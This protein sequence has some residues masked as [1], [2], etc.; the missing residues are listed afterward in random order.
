MDFPERL[1]KAEK[2]PGAAR[3]SPCR[4]VFLDSAMPP[5]YPSPA[6]GPL[7][8]RFGTRLKP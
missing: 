7:P 5:V 8:E 2:A 4:H 3:L 1:V 6:T